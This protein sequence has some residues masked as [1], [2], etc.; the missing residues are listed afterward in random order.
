MTNEMMLFD[1]Q[2][3]IML[4]RYPNEA[5]NWLTGQP[6]DGSTGVENYFQAIPWLFRGTMLRA[7]AVSSMPFAIYKGEEEFETSAEYENKLGVIE[8][9]RR[10]LK[11]IEM[12]LTLMGRAYLF[13]IRN[14]VRTLELK[15]L[16]PITMQPKLD[17]TEGLLGFIRTLTHEVFYPVEDIIYFWNADPYVEIGEPQGSPAKAALMAAG[18]LSNVDEFVASFFKRGAIKTT[19]FSAK[20]V[21]QTDA[22]KF[23]TWFEKQMAGIQNAFRTKILNAEDMKPVVIGEGIDSLQDNA[24]TKEKR[25]DIATALGIPHSLLFSDAANFATAQ[26][27][28]LHFYSKTIVPDCWIIQSILNERVYKPMGYMLKFLPET[29]DV[30]QTDENER[31][32]ALAHLVAAQ[33]PLEV[34]L[35][36]LGFE[37]TDEDWS[38][39]EQER[40][41]R[42]ERADEI[43]AGFAES[44]SNEQEEEPPDKVSI[45]LDKWRRKALKRFRNDK[46]ASCP[47]QSEHIPP[48]L[49]GAILGMLDD[50]KTEEDIEFIFSDEWRDYP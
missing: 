40:K 6:D 33:L 15:Y 21:G 22:K 18:V 36:V 35:R 43:T 17:E 8:D 5:W 41:E 24:L 13:N 9:P 12:S 31:S 38:L 20:G 47:F 14:N 26:Q 1:G 30:F 49:S 10:L 50:A 45:D 23:E 37:L 16:N 3:S 48:A 29:M 39:I 2:K 42:E 7:D 34:S 28:D 25:E 27:D 19:L 32:Q 11:L 4:N 44:D 46:A